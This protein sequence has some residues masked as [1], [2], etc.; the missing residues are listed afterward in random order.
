MPVHYNTG[1]KVLREDLR[2][3]LMTV[4]STLV[5]IVVGII[6]FAIT[7]AI[8]DVS[9]WVLLGADLDENWAVLSA[10][11]VTLGS[12]LGGSLRQRTVLMMNQ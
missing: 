7:L 12:M 3:I 11:I 4:L 10:A 9:A 6:Y 1:G 5:L 2:S 8:I